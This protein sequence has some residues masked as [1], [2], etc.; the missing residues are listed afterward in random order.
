MFPLDE[1]STEVYKLIQPEIVVTSA[2]MPADFGL[3]LTIPAAFERVV[4]K[5]PEAI[6]IRDR[7]VD[8]SYGRLNAAAN[9]LGH[10]ILELRGQTPEP[11]ALLLQHGAASLLALLAVLKSGKF[12]VP[13]DPSYPSSRLSEFLQDC[14]APII[15]TNT[16]NWALAV[17]MQREVP[18][19]QIVNLDALDPRLSSEDPDQV[20]SPDAL[21]SIY[22]TSGSTGQPKGVTQSHWTMLHN[23]TNHIVV[24]EMGPGD[25]V[26]HITTY[27]FAA[28]WKDIFPTLLSGAT[29]CTYD[30]QQGG[31]ADLTAW[32]HR[33]QITIVDPVFPSFLRR[34]LGSLNRKE[35]FS[36]VRRIFLGIEPLYQRDLNLISR[37]FPDNCLVYYILSSTEAGTVTAN[38]VD[39][40]RVQEQ[41]ISVGRAL[42]GFNVL[43]LDEEGHPVD[44]EGV[45]EMRIR[46]RYL[47]PG[48]WRRPDLT[49]IAFADDPAGSDER[50]FKTGDLVRR[51]ADGSLEHLGRKDFRVKVR[52]HTVQLG[53]IENALAGD[54]SIEEAAVV[55]YPNQYGDH[56]LVAYVV[57]RRRELTVSA[58]RSRLRKRLPAY[59]LPAAFM[60]IDRLPR[61]PNG[62]VDRM[63]LPLPTDER[64]ALGS[65]L[66]P[67]RDDVELELTQIWEM[68]LHVHPI[69][70]Q[71]NFF[72]LGGD[73]LLATQLLLEIEM[74]FGKRMPLAVITQAPT[75]ELLAPHVR[76]ETT[77]QSF[78]ARALVPFQPNGS[79]R[80]FFLVSGGGGDDVTMTHYA[81][82]AAY[83]G[84]DQPY[85]G[86]RARGANGGQD[87][88]TRV[89]GMAAD[90][91]REIRT[92][93]PEGP[94]LI[95]GACTGGMVA[96]EIAQQLV[97]HGQRVALLVLLDTRRDNRFYLAHQYHRVTRALTNQST[98]ARLILIDRTRKAISILR[99]RHDQFL[100]YLGGA[101]RRAW[102]G[103]RERKTNRTTTARAA[104]PLSYAD[105]LFT[106]RPS[107]YP[108]RITLIVN[109]DWYRHHHVLGWKGLAADGIEV[110][111]VP[112][113]HYDFFRKNAKWAGRQLKACLDKAQQ[114]ASHDFC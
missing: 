49:H 97:A 62:K 10:A 89:E 66:T 105:T 47:S 14:Q 30:L 81:K 90:Y 69:G 67:P 61:A 11:V 22:Y 4:Q 41:V 19:T 99:L 101:A 26:T 71:D 33:E 88:H 106:Y 45:G 20:V 72:E 12:Y 29:L 68:L 32:L 5:H 82:F 63:R 74:I 109:E 64:P 1:V 65:T 2:Q 114:E 98:Q 83:L 111:R 43:L 36:S 112:G 37:H 50:F 103:F 75:I 13:L 23:A 55:A 87:P 100:P 40:R 57:T 27:A 35:Q 39:P 110:H 113:N 34:F 46:S 79:K 85:Y 77:F 6:A 16:K 56:R 59:M 48:Y 58:L 17:E 96:W 28:S 53:E 24:N 107:T 80:P 18:G 25:R 86:L 51:R 15:A 31:F 44:G 95:G 78:V 73:S 21:A 8:F 93:Q 102:Q 76:K 104:P 42:P 94:Y 108:G 70:I 9:R 92:V 3:E 52:A 54:E 60:F 91:L 84:R 38:L 7:G